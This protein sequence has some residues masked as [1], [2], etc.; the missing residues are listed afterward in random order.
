MVSMHQYPWSGGSGEAIIL[1]IFPPQGS[2]RQ[3]IYKK[4]PVSHS[5]QL[6]SVILSGQFGLVCSL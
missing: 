1:G 5:G 3:E 6:S 4:R 2:N